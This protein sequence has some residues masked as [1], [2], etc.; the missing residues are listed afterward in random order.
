MGDINYYESR[1]RKDNKI[2]Y[3]DNIFLSKYMLNNIENAMQYFYTC[4]FYTLR[5]KMSLN[6]KIRTGRI[7][8][9]DDEGYI[10]NIVYDNLNILKE[11]EPSDIVS[12]HIYYNTNSIFH[13]CLSQKYKMNNINCTK[14][15]Q[16]FC[17]V[18]GKIYSMRNIQKVLMK[19]IK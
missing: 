18:N 7:I 10:F 5:S 17:I 14:I 19:N 2:E 6:E 4:P 15:I 16:Y 11:N 1:L 13:I 12:M 3:V 8:N 9:D